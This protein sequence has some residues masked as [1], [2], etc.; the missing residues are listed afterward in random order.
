MYGLGPALFHFI[1]T[2]VNFGT[3]HSKVEH[4]HP[5]GVG[6][7]GVHPTSTV[8]TPSGDVAVGQWKAKDSGG[9]TLQA[10]LT[11]GSPGHADPLDVTLFAAGGYRVEASSASIKIYDL[12]NTL[13]VELP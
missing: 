8:T 9:W 2:H 11:P 5:L 13:T 12:A 7:N 1:Y 3:G 6:G 10:N 4:A